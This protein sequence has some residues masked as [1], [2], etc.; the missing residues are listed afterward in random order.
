MIFKSEQ[1]FCRMCGTVCRQSF[2][3]RLRKV[4]FLPGLSC[5]TWSESLFY[6]LRSLCLV[7]E[8]VI[9]LEQ[10]YFLILK[11]K[12]ANVVL[13]LIENKYSIASRSVHFVILVSICADVDKENIT[14]R[15]LV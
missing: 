14:N 3:N 11:I 12:K 15:L 2:R 4:V 5:R 8:P 9:V 10:V 1:I 6:I 7:G 13:V